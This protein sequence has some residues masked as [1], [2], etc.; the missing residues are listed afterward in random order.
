MKL[1]N[2][3]YGAFNIMKLDNVKCGTL[4]NVRGHIGYTYRF[5]TARLIHRVGKINLTYDCN[6]GNLIV[7]E[8]YK[9]PEDELKDMVDELKE[10]F[11]PIAF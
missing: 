3:K 11:K 2:A 1:E 8:W 10:Y 9:I 4:K 6:T 7:H 5:I